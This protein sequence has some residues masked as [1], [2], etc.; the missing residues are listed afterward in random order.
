MPLLL[1]Q[2][3][4]ECVQN[5]RL[6]LSRKRKSQLICTD[7]ALYVTVTYNTKY[8]QQCDAHD[9]FAASNY[10]NTILLQVVILLLF[11]YNINRSCTRQPNENVKQLSRRWVPL[12][13]DYL[14]FNKC[15]LI[16]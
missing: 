2:Y 9:E 13:S 4:V 10:F 1:T 15:H 12:P 3:E 8:I 14:V 11:L 5:N 16:K 7:K 6:E